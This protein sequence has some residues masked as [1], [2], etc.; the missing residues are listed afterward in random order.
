MGWNTTCRSTTSTAFYYYRFTLAL[1]VLFPPPPPAPAPTPQDAIDGDA[2][3]E[4]G[5]LS[6][7][8]SDNLDDLVGGCAESG[9][10]MAG[11]R[12]G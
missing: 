8:A 4:G 1:Q 10:L 9:L 2:D 7:S 6:G 5:L 3:G 11:D 12:R